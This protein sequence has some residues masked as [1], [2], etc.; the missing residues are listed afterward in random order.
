M[1][2]Q[3]Q[4]NNFGRERSGNVA[5][6]PADL[7]TDESYLIYRSPFLGYTKTPRRLEFTKL[8]RATTGLSSRWFPDGPDPQT[9]LLRSAIHH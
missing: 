5:S 7:G 6:Y 8:L 9:F 3:S 1:A 2:G 4:E